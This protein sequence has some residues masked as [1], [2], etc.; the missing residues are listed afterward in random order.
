MKLAIKILNWLT[1]IIGLVI[2]LS[3]SV[4]GII[5]SINAMKN[6]LF[7]YE[8]IK[9]FILLVLAILFLIPSIVCFISNYQLKRVKTRDNL[10][11]MGIITLLFGN[12]ISGIL[13][14]CINDNDL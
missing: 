1:I 9:G 3:L 7:Y 12:L 10:K 13:M 6:S 2:T 11:V 8:V 4:F 5:I 14:L